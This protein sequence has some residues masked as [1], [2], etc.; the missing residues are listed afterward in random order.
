MGLPQSIIGQT[1]VSLPNLRLIVAQLTMPSARFSRV[2]VL[3]EV[4]VSRRAVAFSGKSS[5][6]FGDLAL[7][8]L[9]YD[10]T[11]IVPKSNSLPTGRIMDAFWSIWSTFGMKE[12]WINEKSTVKEYAH[13]MKRRYGTDSNAAILILSAGRQFEASD[14]RDHIYA[15]LGHPALRGILKPDYGAALDHVCLALAQRLLCSGCSLNMLTFVDNSDDG[16]LRSDGSPPSWAPQWHTSLTYRRYPH[17]HWMSREIKSTAHETIINVSGNRLYIAALL[18][19]TVNGCTQTLGGPLGNTGVAA[20]NSHLAY[21]V[22]QLWNTFCDSRKNSGVRAVRMSNCLHAFIWTLVYGRYPYPP[23][24]EADFDSFCKHYGASDFSQSFGNEISR[25]N[26]DSTMVSSIRFRQ[27]MDAT[28][29]N[30][31]FF[32]TTDGR[33]GIGP[34]TIRDGDMVALIFGCNAPLIL[35]PTSTPDHYKLSGSSFIFDLVYNTTM[36]MDQWRNGLLQKQEI[37]LM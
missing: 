2:W 10:S 29:H 32:T 27:A 8:V 26:S 28:F 22:Q 20:T 7:F 12:S 34:Q 16:L 23:L 31:R 30:K 24:V 37:V 18:V 13:E 9:V 21:K 3:Q 19:D 25:S 6:P 36:T 35:R 11:V 4:G 5:L 1:L 15:F 33:C 14:D 17:E